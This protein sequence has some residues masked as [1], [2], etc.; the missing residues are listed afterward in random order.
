MELRETEERFRSLAESVPAL[1]WLYD[2]VADANLFVNRRF[3][4]V[5]RSG[6]LGAAWPRA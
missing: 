1:I 2:V 6:G 3:C 5:C 4:E